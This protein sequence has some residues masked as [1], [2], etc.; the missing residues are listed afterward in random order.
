MRTSGRRR[1]RPQAAAFRGALWITLIAVATTVVALTV[2]HVQTA[3]LIDTEL[4]HL[5]AGE[6]DALTLRY[7]DGGVGGLAIYIDRQVR[8]SSRDVVYM[9]AD[10]RGRRIAGSVTAWPAG[11]HEGAVTTFA[12]RVQNAGGGAERRVEG[13]TRTLGPDAQLLVGH[14][15]DSRI[16]LGDRYWISL[17]LSIAI[18][19]AL[20]LALGWFVSR[21]GL[22]FVKQ[23]AESGDRFLAGHL[24]ER[25]AVSD[26]DDEFDRLSEVVNAC[27]DEIERMVGSLRAATDGL[28]HDLK[29]PLTRI[30]AR[31]ELAA[32]RSDGGSQGEVLAET[33]RD[34]DAML[35]LINGL[36]AL[37]RADATTADSFEPLD[38]STIVR[39][40]LDLYAPLAEDQ[41]QR[42]VIELEPAPVKGVPS[43]LLHAAAN[44]IDNAVKHSPRGGKV[45]VRTFLDQGSACLSVADQGPGI[46]PELREQ[47]L[48]RFGRLDESRS[49]PGSGL[50]L[51]L[52][53][54]V[55]RLHR[56]QLLLTDNKPG[57]RADLRFGSEPR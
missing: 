42:L 5:I 34:L 29:T 1:G 24:D 19:A 52:V 55:A 38:L 20:S 4:D 9:L 22:R 45:V 21:R 26:R 15:A 10:R 43:L 18:T 40:A 32:L 33:A 17:L 13:Q 30:K 46:A 41:G 53:Q 6:T 14:L 51:T 28:A 2:Q 31:M 7:Q 23:A 44:L 57:L 39:E 8:T 37:A 48:R 11:L 12:V 35:H 36:L 16:A 25:L 47:A 3:R 49:T 27:F 56:G 50:G 54:T